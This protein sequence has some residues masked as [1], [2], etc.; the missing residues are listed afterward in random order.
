MESLCKFRFR[1]S[2]LCLHYRLCRHSRLAS[3][4]LFIFS[5]VKSIFSSIK[6]G[7]NWETMAFFV[8][9]LYLFISS[10][11]YPTGPVTFLLL[12]CFAGVF[13]VLRLLI[14]I[15]AKFL[16]ILN[17]HRKSFSPC[18][19]LFLRLFFP[20][21]LFTYIGR[22]LR[23]RILEKRSWLQLFPSRR[24]FHQQ[25]LAYTKMIYTCALML[26]YI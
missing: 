26:R 15:T 19:L 4:G 18:Y 8:L 20:T 13:C 5:G 22:P 16:F 24:H 23:F 11:F 17:D 14:A 6:N 12:S 2:Q 1:T 9:S 25:N 10:F 3:F 7:V 21:A